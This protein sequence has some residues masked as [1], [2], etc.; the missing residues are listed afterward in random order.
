MSHLEPLSDADRAAIIAYLDGELDEAAAR[1]VEARLSRDPAARAEAEALRRTWELLD[2][3]PRAEP[4]PGFTQRTLERI[5]TPLPATELPRR[6]RP[7]AVGLGWAA[8]VVVAAG[9]G[10]AGVT[11]LLP[12]EP[13]D[14]ELARDLTVLENRRLYEQADSLDFLRLLDGPDLFGDD[15]PEAG[16]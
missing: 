5:T 1:R 9:A 4:P 10:F 7:W 15:S 16:G 3:L 12:R 2:F 6:W 14:E 8:A 11:L 13:T